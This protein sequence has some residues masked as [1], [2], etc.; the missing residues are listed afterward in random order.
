MVPVSVW[1]LW[2][3]VSGSPLPE[4]KRKAQVLLLSG[5]RVLESVEEAEISGV[6]MWLALVELRH[7][8]SDLRCQRHNVSS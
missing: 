1:I 6:W 4:W 8:K 2:A 7:I 3:A 5:L